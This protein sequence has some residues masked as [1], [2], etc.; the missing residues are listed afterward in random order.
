MFYRY[1]T[2]FYS[3]FR[4][5]RSVHL[6]FD[7]SEDIVDNT[8]TPKNLPNIEYLSTLQLAG[9]LFSS[10]AL[11][12][13][14]TSISWQLSAIPFDSRS[15]DLLLASDTFSSAFPLQNSSPHY[16]QSSSQSTFIL[17]G[18]EFTCD[19][20][21][22]RK[23]E[24]QEEVSMLDGTTPAAY[25]FPGLAG[26]D[27]FSSLVPILQDGTT[28]CTTPDTSTCTTSS[29]SPIASTR[30]ETPEPDPISSLIKAEP[31]DD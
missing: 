11:F 15:P 14:D 30:M 20:F 22:L 7:S 23:C 12:N 8:E 19:G 25:H 10:E 16:F 1:V 4:I 29:I 6:A 9:D 2:S 18:Y 3:W 31:V 27:L 21:L 24:P 13:L 26:L 28:T 17:D 5:T